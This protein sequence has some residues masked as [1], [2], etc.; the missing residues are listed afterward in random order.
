MGNTLLSTV[1]YP[2]IMTAILVLMWGL[3][4]AGSS[5]REV[6]N[7]RHDSFKDPSCDWSLGNS[8]LLNCPNGHAEARLKHDTYYGLTRRK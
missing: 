8:H 5:S 4:A 6:N 3:N 2:I 1:F 7:M